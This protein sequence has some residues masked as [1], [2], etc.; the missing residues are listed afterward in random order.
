MQT[1]I[2]SCSIQGRMGFE[3]R[4]KKKVEAHRDFQAGL[5]TWSAWFLAISVAWWHRQDCSVTLYDYR[6]HLIRAMVFAGESVSNEILESYPSPTGSLRV[7]P[8]G[9]YY[10][11]DC[12]T[13]GVKARTS[14]GGLQ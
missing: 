13:Q 7:P 4:E 9:S 6:C 2:N 8:G 10:Y 1:L 5:I 12:Q 11:S 14:K 3:E